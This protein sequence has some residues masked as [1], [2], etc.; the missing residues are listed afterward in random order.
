M[1]AEPIFSA[2]EVREAKRWLSFLGEDWVGE[3]PTRIH[4]YG[5]FGLGSAPPFTR[6]FENYIGTLICKDPNCGICRRREKETPGEGYLRTNRQEERLKATR[7]FRKLRRHAP[8]EYDVLWLAV[9]QHNTIHEITDKL[10]ERAY[11]KG[12]ADRYTTTDVAIL[13]MSGIDKVRR[14]L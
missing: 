2:A 8:L 12:Y 9:M 10:N 6:E 14:W 4:E 11:T 7:V 1:T 13:A 5:T 3:V